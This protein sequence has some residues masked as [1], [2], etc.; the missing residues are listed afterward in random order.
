MSKSKAKG[1]AY[2]TALVRYFNNW[3]GEDV[4]ERIVLYGNKDHGDMRLKVDDLVLT[5][6]AKWRK[7][8]P[9]RAEELDFRRQT[10]KET[11]NAGTDGGIL[12]VNKFNQS[13]S[14]SEVW[15]N[16]NTATQLYT[17]E[18]VEYIASESD[19]MCMRL[20]DFCYTCF[21]PKSTEGLYGS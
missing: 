18:L 1:T 21:G 19:W 16:V 2:E 17:R 14:R 20:D 6:E 15:M 12:V 5:V 7:Q 10:D 13:I 4:C 8:Y 9:N 11:A 3:V